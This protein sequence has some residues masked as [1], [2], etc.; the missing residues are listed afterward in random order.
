M[1]LLVVYFLQSLLVIY[2]IWSW[3]RHFPLEV[4][5][6]QER[7]MHRKQ[8]LPGFILHLLSA[9]ITRCFV[10]VPKSLEVPLQTVKV[11]DCLR[12]VG[13]ME[14]TL[15]WQAS[16]EILTSW[17][18]WNG[19]GNPWKLTSNILD[20]DQ[21]WN[22]S[23]VRIL[24]PCLCKPFAFAYVAGS[25]YVSSFFQICRYVSLGNSPNI[26]CRGT[27]LSYTAYAVCYG[28][29]TLNEQM[30]F[31]RTG[32]AAWIGPRMHIVSCWSH[33]V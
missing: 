22:T 2:H 9:K 8:A 21:T 33:T 17:E 27:R 32:W 24:G 19:I 1:C 11:V 13:P 3:Q 16:A 10:F 30:S 29:R 15:C 12:F 14:S 18:P 6:F 4:S 23:N 31:W 5:S 26:F 7:S 20:F 25:F 28:P